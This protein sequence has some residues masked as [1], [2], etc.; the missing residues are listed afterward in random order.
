[1]RHREPAPSSVRVVD[2][3]GAHPFASRRRSRHARGLTRCAQPFR[4]AYERGD[5]PARVEHG[6]GR[7]S[8]RWRRDIYSPTGGFL[9]LLP[10]FFDGLCE[11]AHPF[12]FLAVRGCEELLVAAKARALPLL[13][14]LVPPLRRALV[15]RDRAVVATGLL[16][17]QCLVNTVPGAGLAL[18]PHYPR[19]LPS[20]R[21]L[22]RLPCAA[23]DGHDY[24]QRVRGPRNLAAIVD[25]TL[26]VLL[27]SG[28]PHAAAH[29]T[30]VVPTFQ[31][32]AG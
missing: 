31:S 20:L 6:T 1:M 2:S 21:L 3:G 15:S 12:R 26:Q 24:G 28:G 16:M 8:L 19:L 32:V 5:V 18:L 27:R 11:T 22:S 13:P 23:R 4:L 30:R 25:E 17:L 9:D 29:I 14:L 7:L 10:L